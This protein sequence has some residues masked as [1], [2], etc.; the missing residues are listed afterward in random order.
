MKPEIYD[1]HHTQDQHPNDLDD[2]I[3]EDIDSN[4]DVTF[5]DIQHS[6]WVVENL[7]PATVYPLHSVNQEKTTLDNNINPHTCPNKNVQ[8]K[9]LLMYQIHLE[10]MLKH[11]HQVSLFLQERINEI[12]QI[13]SK[14][15]RDLSKV[16]CYSKTQLI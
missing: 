11:N 10:Y 5:E 4:F 6:H 14:K 13:Y 1:H 8:L 3:N 9:L 2:D 12:I 15:G 16:K 7:D